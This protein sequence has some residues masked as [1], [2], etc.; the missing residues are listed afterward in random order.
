M[1][2]DLLPCNNLYRKLNFKACP[3]LMALFSQIIGARESSMYLA[4]WKSNHQVSSSGVTLIVKSS[5][6]SADW[7]HTE[8]NNKDN[9]R[10]HLVD[11]QYWNVLF[12]LIVMKSRL[13]NRKNRFMFA[14]MFKY[15]FN[16][17]L[18]K[19]NVR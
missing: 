6:K 2:Q 3:Q 1:R 4:L 11:H 5:Q 13:P 8:N 17:F 7:E 14:N 18:V 19:E 12:F 16:F 9:L 15:M 10:D